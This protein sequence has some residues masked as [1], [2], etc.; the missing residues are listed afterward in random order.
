MHDCHLCWTTVVNDH[1]VA[2]LVALVSSI[3]RGTMGRNGVVWSVWQSRQGNGA[4]MACMLRVA[5]SGL[6]P[7][8]PGNLC[9]ALETAT[10]TPD[11][12]SP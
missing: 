1:R 2:V 12:S 3:A 10:A 8:V 11:Y 4:T 6:R 7:I 5:A 9:Y